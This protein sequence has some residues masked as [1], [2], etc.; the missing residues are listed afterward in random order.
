M[1]KVPT[2]KLKPGDKVTIAGLRVTKRGI[3]LR[4][5]PGNETVFTVQDQPAKSRNG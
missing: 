5:K 2:S 1:S 3:T 4:C